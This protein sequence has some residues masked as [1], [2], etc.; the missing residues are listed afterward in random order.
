MISKSF[1]ETIAVREVSARR[2][3]VAFAR[4]GSDVRWRSGGACA[5]RVSGR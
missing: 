2:R 3:S 1:A 4:T 5:W